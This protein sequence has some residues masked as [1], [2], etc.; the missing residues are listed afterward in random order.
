MWHIFKKHLTCTKIPKEHS[1]GDTQL[2]IKVLSS[3][4]FWG[5]LPQEAWIAWL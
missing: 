2:V 3:L 5:N 1:L 4:W